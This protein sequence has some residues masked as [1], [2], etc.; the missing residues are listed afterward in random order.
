MDIVPVI[1]LLGGQVVHARQ[2]Q[3]ETY[4][5]IRTPLSA[6]SRPADVTAGLLHLFPF[7]RVYVADLDAIERRPANDAGVA[8]LSAAAPDIDVW[9]DSGVA[10][11]EGARASLADGAHSVVIGSESQGGTDVLRALSGHPG[12][13][14]SLDFRGDAFQGPPELL[15]DT[16]LWPR[17]V[18][19]MTLARVGAGRGPDVARVAAIAERAPECLIYAAGGVRD[20]DDLRALATAGAVGALVATALH[21]GALSA[22]DLE[23]ITRPPPPTPSRKGRG[24]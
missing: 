4:R 6:T 13:I 14:L 7:R 18:I 22:A 5:P 3:R 19:V 17:R 23:A 21:N 11:A 12:V 24:S 10:E 15:S 1:D 20:A 8:A 9:I 16:A 2:G